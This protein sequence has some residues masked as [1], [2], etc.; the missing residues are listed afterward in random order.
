MADV[1]PPVTIYG[2]FMT[3]LVLFDLYMSRGRSA[4]RNTAYGILGGILLFVLC[5]AGMDFVAWGM[6]LLPIIFYLFLFAV[7]LFDRSF[8]SVTHKY[9]PTRNHNGILPGGNECGG[10]CD[11]EP[12]TCTEDC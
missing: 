3:A 7:I 9:S 6:L 12:D 11:P 5:A 4:M 1:C 8:L 2:V 10:G